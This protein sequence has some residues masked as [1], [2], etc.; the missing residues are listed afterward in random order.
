MNIQ[1]K[2]LKVLLL[3]LLLFL[4]PGCATYYSKLAP[5]RTDLEKGQ[6]QKAIETLKP[7][8][9]T[10]SRDQLAYLLDYATVLQISGNTKESNQALIKADKLAEQLDY[11]SVSKV[12]SSL[13]M[14][15]EFVQYKGDTFEKVFINAYLAMNFLSLGDLDSALVEA[16]RINEKYQKYRADEKVE[17][18]LNPFS[19]YLSAIIW[20][21]DGKYDDAYIAF[22][23]AHKIN[24]QIAGIEEDLIRTAKL[25]RRDDSYKTWKKTFP[26]VQE[27][28]KWYD[29]KF[30]EIIVLVQQGWGPQ[31]VQ[32]QQAASMPTFKLVP[33]RTDYV[34]LKLNEGQNNKLS[35]VVYDVETAAI[36]TLKEDQGI[37]MAK[38]TAA[39]GTKLVVADQVR[40]KNQLAGDL[41]QIAMMASERADLRQWSLLPKTIQIIR[42]PVLP[43]TYDVHL[44]GLTY[45][46]DPTGE[47]L[48][49]SV[50][51]QAGKKS[52]LIW[53]T[54]K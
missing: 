28:P 16:R 21:A 41:L 45:S 6:Y 2:R 37:L 3:S 43:G 49:R 51:V 38:R 47:T 46:Q 44:E 13:V 5:V 22:Q 15:E 26:Q 53:R 14:N 11:F 40:Q 48:S 10:E 33:S 20:E 30:G 19:K 34:R 39:L 17:Y 7:Q 4:T 31:K 27:D 52:F 8:A 23:D 54:L 25:A 29:K 36:E 42:L 1:C 35:K 24:P 9:Q 12:S 50:S 18:K 32:S